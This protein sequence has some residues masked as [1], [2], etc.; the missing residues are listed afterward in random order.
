MSFSGNFKSRMLFMDQ[1]SDQTNYRWV[2]FEKIWE[3][4]QRIGMAM[5]MRD[6]PNEPIA[7]T[8]MDGT[9]IVYPKFS[10][11][12]RSTK[13]LIQDMIDKVAI[14]VREDRDD[15]TYSRT[16]VFQRKLIYA[17]GYSLNN[18]LD[19]SDFLEKKFKPGVQRVG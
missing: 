9:I 4:G 5:V 18:V 19:F 11:L 14:L 2:R 3:D 16:R 15:L 6:E 12:D 1:S 17:K 7:T 13:N 8:Y 10:N